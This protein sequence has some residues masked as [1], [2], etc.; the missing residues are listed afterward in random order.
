MNPLIVPALSIVGVAAAIALGL[1][2]ATGIIRR[3]DATKYRQLWLKFLILIIITVTVL[4]AGAIGKWGLFPLA[5]FLAYCG[6]CELIQSIEKKY[7]EIPISP[8]LPILGAL[9]IFGGIGGSDLLTCWGGMIGAWLAI[10]LPMLITR[11]PPPMHGILAVGFGTVAIGIPLC[12][13]LNLL[14]FSYSLYIFF[15]LLVM[16][17]DGFSEVFGQLLG[18][19]PLSPHISPN[20]T[21]E[22]VLGGFLSCLILGYSIKF[23]ISHWQLWQLLTISS[24]VSVLALI[25]DLIFSS[26]KR[27]AGIKDYGN[28]LAVTGGILDKFDSL[29]FSIPVFYAIARWIEST[30]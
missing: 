29:L 21:W 30:I 8:L 6:W 17:N 12:Y 18:R 28:I 4:S 15:I 10:A 26:L 9:G 5:L 23:M 24:I 20:K 27:E 13:L 16:F 19:T 7:G 3:P 14:E 22:G 1:I 25:G 2:V 11:R